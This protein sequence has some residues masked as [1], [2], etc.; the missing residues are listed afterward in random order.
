MTVALLAQTADPQALLRV[1]AIQQVMNGERAG[2]GRREPGRRDRLQAVRLWQAAGLL[3]QQR[4]ASQAADEYCGS[5]SPGG[6]SAAR[7]ACS[8]GP[9]RRG[10]GSPPPWP[11]PG[12]VRRPRPPPP[13]PTPP[14]SPP[15]PPP[16]HRRN[17]FQAGRPIPDGAS[18]GVTAPA[19]ALSAG[20]TAAQGTTAA[21]WALTQLGKPYQ[22]G[23]AG[24]QSYDCSGLA[25][26][27]WARAGVRLDH[28]T[29]FQWV[30]GPHLPL[31][32][33]RRGDLVFY[34]TNASPTP[35]PSITWAST[36]AMGS[37]STHR[38]PARWC[39][40]T[41]STRMRASSARPA[42]PPDSPALTM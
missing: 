32:Q 15:P 21:N 7:P 9:R 6:R 33:L 10:Q 25:M 4:A 40:S 24:P 17:G 36:S 26:D 38:T 5:R 14:P 23:G 37:W 35:P 3:A 28:W 16:H 2:P 34:A 29:G 13:T 18:P 1:L 27:A 12:R 20:A 30:S 39:A 22:W 31:S 19:W 8:R 41:A 42:Q 11:A